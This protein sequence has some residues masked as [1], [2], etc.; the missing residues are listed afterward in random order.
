MSTK[1]FTGGAGTG[2]TTSLLLELNAY[3]AAH[4]LSDGQRVLALTFMHGS[5]HRLAER[6]A[7]SS[8][9]R[10]CECMTLDRFAWEICRRWRSRLRAG[11]GL[12]PLDLDAPDYDATC[13]AAGRLLAAPEVAKWVAARYPVLVLD[14]FQD[15]DPVRLA[16]AQHLHGRVNMFVAAD[17][18]QNLN[19]TDESPGV[20]WL[21]G[22]NVSQELTI[23]RRTTNADLIAAAHALRTGVTLPTSFSTSFK[24]ISAPSPAVAASFISQTMAPAAGKDVVLLSAARSG[25]S[26]WVDKV[27][28][29]V[30]T[31]QYGNQK[32]GP[33]PIKWENT[34]DS[35]AE[36]MIV[37]LGIANGNREISASAIQALPRDRVA[38]QL[39]RWVEHQ[40]RVL[41]RIEFRATEVRAQVKRAVQ[42]VRS[43]GST[44][45]GGRRAMTIHQAK[46]REF[47][48]VIVLW[49]FQV[50]GDVALARRWLYNAITRAKRRAIVIVQDPKKKRL[51]APP[52]AYPPAVAALAPPP[53]PPRA[54][55][56][57]QG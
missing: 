36:T 11:G 8:A 29:F 19:R 7:K 6:L 32:A 55:P 48:V 15:C 20:T 51:N 56:R 18:F 43:F 47:Q 17:D 35:V 53:P 2:K 42:H 28:E 24:L 16:L 34:A 12:V 5:R 50:V 57:L 31:K 9:R 46:N 4:P 39:N 45:Q 22:L 27:I 44:S 37:A 10:H 13:E 25:T 14:E 38:T 52:F 23:N 49:P 1:G 21:R 41:G 40:R 26:A 30:T 33:V 3:L 54:T